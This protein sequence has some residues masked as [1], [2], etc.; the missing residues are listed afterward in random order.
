MDKL[1]LVF[2]EESEDLL[3]NLEQSLL[4]LEKNTDD[5]NR[6]DEVFRAMHT[7]KG[8]SSMF[9]FFK[10]SDFV[11][12][13]ETLYSLIRDK[14]IEATKKIIDC[15]FDVLDLLKL[16]VK[17][18]IV[19]EEGNLKKLAD[20]SN[21]IISFLETIETGK[22]QIKKPNIQPEATSDISE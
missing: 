4:S 9:G 18:P 5:E 6:I 14:K 12:N 13:L 16:L 15:T 20:L 3:L 8:N 11:H 10:I 19:T 22:Q 7:L 1:Q 2:R 21:R 17:D